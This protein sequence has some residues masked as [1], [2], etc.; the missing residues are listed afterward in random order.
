MPGILPDR[1]FNDSVRHAPAETASEPLHGFSAA[2]YEARRNKAMRE[3]RHMS[4]SAFQA[5]AM[6][7]HGIPC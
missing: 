1:R 2:L 5:N 3:V 4:T 7:L 6:E